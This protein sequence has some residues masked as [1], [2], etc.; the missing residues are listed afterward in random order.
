MKMT[1]SRNASS[2]SR[3]HAGMRGIWMVALTL[4]AA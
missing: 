2:A 1:F 3:R 4:V